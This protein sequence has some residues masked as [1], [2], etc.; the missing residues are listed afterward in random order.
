[1]PPSSA[2]T[3]MYLP[4]PT[5]HFV[6]SRQVSMFVKAVASG[7]GDLDDPLDRDVPHG[8]PVEQRPVLLDRVGVV[9]R[10]VHVVVDV[11]GAAAR[12]ERL[13]EERRA[14]V[15]RPEIEGRR[16]LGGR[17]R[18]RC[19][20]RDLTAVEAVAWGSATP[21]AVAPAPIPFS[22]PLGG[23]VVTPRVD[24][25]SAAQNMKPSMPEVVAAR[26]LRRDRASR[27]SRSPS[28]A[29]QRSCCIRAG[30]C[31]L[32]DVEAA[33]QACRRE[34]RDRRVVLRVL[35][36]MCSCQ[37]A[38]AP[39]ALGWLRRDHRVGVVEDGATRLAASRP[40]PSGRCRSASGRRPPGRSSGAPSD[41]L[42][43]ASY[44]WTAR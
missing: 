18:E 38:V 24:G 33:G 26:D 32:G 21:S 28:G 9:A 35:P 42:P 43:V 4:W 15:P 7:P 6:R 36:S 41:R 22:Q 20:H 12:L 39:D 19:R 29:T 44:G 1:M 23:W 17:R 14:P 13:L 11:V 3:S 16:G 5:A 27:S 10:Q 2:V 40:W 25:R 8:H 31:S 34:R 37:F 30:P